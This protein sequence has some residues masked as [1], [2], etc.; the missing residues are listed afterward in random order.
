[1]IY[2]KILLM[3][4]SLLFI[5]CG[6]SQDSNNKIQNDNNIKNIKQNNNQDIVFSL[7]SVDDASSPTNGI[8][9]IK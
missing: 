2:K 8:K 4:I 3:A 7:P 1:M 6:D 9:H 5:S